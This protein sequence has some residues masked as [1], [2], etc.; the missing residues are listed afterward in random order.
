MVNVVFLRHHN[1]PQNKIWF[2]LSTVPFPNTIREVLIT[3]RIEIWRNG[4]FHY[5]RDLFADK[6]KNLNGE[7]L[8]V[9]YLE[10]V[11]SVLS[12][13]SNDTKIIGGIEIEVSLKHKHIFF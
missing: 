12:T 1:T 8:N 9:A 11:P 3:R 13:N 6:T 7:T 2:D 10:H 5:N 4:K